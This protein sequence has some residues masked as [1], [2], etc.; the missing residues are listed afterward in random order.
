M[1]KIIP[2]IVNHPVWSVS[3]LL[4]AIFFLSIRIN[5]LEVN[6][7][8]E[9][10][11]PRGD[12]QTDYYENTFKQTFGSDVLSIIVIKPVT[13]D[14]FSYKTLT[15]I[16]KLTGDLEALEDVTKVTSLT[17]VNM[18]KGE[19]DSLNTNKLTGLCT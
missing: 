11:L 6:T 9:Q 8:L 12:P 7:D 3:F 15:F 16:E 19:E 13:G 4:F 5:T 18:I 1:R 2:W 17:T 14:V 10:F